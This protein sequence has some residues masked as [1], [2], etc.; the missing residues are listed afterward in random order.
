ME[1]ESK[2]LE[3]KNYVDEKMEN[4]KVEKHINGSLDK[5]N[6]NPN[7]E[8][9]ATQRRH[10]E[11]SELSFEIFPENAEEKIKRQQI[12]K[13]LEKD[14]NTTLEQWRL[15]ARSEYGLINDDLRQKVWP[16]LVSVDVTQCDPVPTLEELMSHPEYNQ[17]VLDVNRSLKRF[18]P[19]I[20]PAKRLALQDQLTAIILRVISKYPHL[21]YYQGYHDVAVTFLLVC[22]DEIAFHIM[23]IL[24]TDHLVEC[25]Q[26]TFE[27]VQKRLLLIYAIV[28]RENK[29]LYEYLERSQCGLLFA[30]PW[31]LTWFGHSLN[32]YRSVVR[33][34][35]YFLAS[36]PL[37]PLY[38]TA[39]IVLYRE[40]DIYREECDRAS[41]HCLLSQL[42][43]ELPFEY[44]LIQS[45]KLY[46][47]Y[48]P[49]NLHKDIEKII[50]REQKI[51]E[52]EDK[53]FETRRQLI[54]R[55]RQPVPTPQPFIYKLIPRKLILHRRSIFVSTAFIV[56]GI[57]A[58][59]YKAHNNINVDVIR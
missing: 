29:D 53:V 2:N 6:A 4:G 45:E 31:Y 21:S 3:L 8:K 28:W 34:Y 9:K 25:M 18:P 37:L 24:S 54:Q 27:I 35:D 1:C 11:P 36:E 13:A 12:E 47:K 14:S 41:L 49:H 44:L 46:A 16:L 38:V 55:K 26:K 57:F 51:R 23:E 59:Y 52:E 39:A 7:A 30:L 50:E 48:P 43:D 19:S 10:D 58:Y 42:P 33:L 17:V 20:A 5:E 15:F 56:I 22:G 40:E 32:Q